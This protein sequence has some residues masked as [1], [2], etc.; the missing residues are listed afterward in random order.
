MPKVFISYARDESHGQ[1]LAT[2]CQQALQT[3]GFEVFRDVIGLKPGDVWY[4]KLEFE[5]ETSDV[6]VLIV[7]EKVRRSKWVHNEI[8]MAEE[9]GLPVI[10]VFAEAVRSP[11]WLRH[12]QA[13]DFAVTADWPVLISSVASHGI[14]DAETESA[15]LKQ[16]QTPEPV[17]LKPET[18][19]TIIPATQA[20]PSIVTAPS[21]QDSLVSR[22]DQYRETCAWASEVDIDDFGIYADLE[23]SEVVQRFRLIQPG[24][25]WMG[26]PGSEAERS[27]NETRH[28]VTLSKAFWLADT[29]CTQAF[30][31]A[32]MGNNPSH[33]K[34]GPNSPVEGVSWNDIQEFIQ[35][36]NTMQPSLSVQLPT[37]AQWEYACR[38]GTNSLFSFGAK[39]TPEQVNYDGN[40]PYAGG[41]KGLKRGKTVSVKSLEANAW[42]LY[43]M[44]G[45]VW[46]W[47]QDAYKSDLGTEACTDP[48][49]ESGDFRVLRGGSWVSYGGGCRSAC[50]NSYRPDRRLSDFGFRLARGQ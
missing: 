3:A 50:R 44:H 11:L 43:E 46:E 7:S 2:E 15:Q 5:L 48:L 10:P 16:P 23:I 28:Q 41:E 19:T 13:L 22:R 34:G 29:A 4:S 1:N 25:F 36:L 49:N 17:I 39:I 9:I 18:E 30:W 21:I 14:Q 20:S 6:V 40:H 26:A 37:E 42:G 47:C 45:N 35:T 32:V 31:E 33:F 24:T 27:D 12:L 38:A 8:S